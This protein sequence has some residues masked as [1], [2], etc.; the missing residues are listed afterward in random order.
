MQ[1]TVKRGVWYHFVR[2]N[3]ITWVWNWFLMLSGKA[4]EAV[5]TV[6][7]IYSCARLLPT[8]HTPVSLDNTVFVLQMVALDIG[9]LSLRKMANQAKKD[10]NE[11]GA[12]FSSRVSNWLIVIMI[13]NVVLS[14][15][16]AVTPIPAQAVS[17]IE[18]ILLVGRAIMAVLYAHVIHS[19]RSDEQDE[20]PSVK[21]TDLDQQIAD[22]IAD[23][24]RHY[25]T[26]IDDL[27][28]ELEALKMVLKPEVERDTDE[29]ETV[30]ET[31]A[32]A[33][34]IVAE[35]VP[36]NVT[37]ATKSVDEIGDK[38]VAPATEKTEQAATKTGDKTVAHKGDTAAL[39]RAR[40]VVKNNP[41]IRPA[42]LAKRLEI[43]PSYASQLKTKVLA[44]TLTAATIN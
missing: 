20:Q 7:V 13:A 23:A 38:T 35:I 15:V 39:R 3:Y 8:V 40:R 17:I 6:S 22:A 24:T 12:V 10:G 14:V 9:G 32:P 26:Q 2:S 5:L 31:V 27:S 28:N 18:G 1:Q 37:S 34:K 33:P 4:A 44:E 29:I 36:E 16:Q 42:D 43:S 21:F 19:L 30:D 25:T 11:A 41:D